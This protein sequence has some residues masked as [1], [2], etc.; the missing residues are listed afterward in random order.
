VRPTQH[1][2]N[3]RVLLFPDDFKV[4]PGNG[5]GKG[6]VALSWKPS[7]EQLAKMNAGGSVTIFLPTTQPAALEV[8]P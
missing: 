3:N 2:S 4:S 5:S 8:M 7:A 1:P 6:S